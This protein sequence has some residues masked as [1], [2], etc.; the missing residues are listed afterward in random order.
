MKKLFSI[1]VLCCLFFVSLA[2]AQNRKR[3]SKKANIYSAKNNWE[4]GANL[5]LFFVN[6]GSSTGINATIAKFVNNKTQFGLRLGTTFQTGAN[7]LIVGAF[8]KHFIDKFYVGA[9]LEYSRT[10]FDEINAFFII[11][12]PEP[13]NQLTATLDGGYRFPINKKFAIDTGASL[14]IPV[15]NGNGGIALGLHGGIIYKF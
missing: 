8:G 12:K 10:T 13:F 1:T 7:V 5:N 6:G 11:V 9:G 15:S 3:T 2:Q 14:L 4:A